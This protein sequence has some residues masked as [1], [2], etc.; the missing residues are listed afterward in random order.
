M[1]ENVEI[2]RFSKIALIFQNAELC[3]NVAK[4]EKNHSQP[5]CFRVEGRFLYKQGAQKFIPLPATVHRQQGEISER[6]I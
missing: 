4:T 2:L 5:K 3:A 6:K 1:S